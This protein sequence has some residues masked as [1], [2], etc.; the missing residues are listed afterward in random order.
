M[1]T[2]KKFEHSVGLKLEVQVR[3]TDVL[4]EGETWLSRT[5]GISGL[6]GSH[7][8]HIGPTVTEEKIEP[9]KLH[10]LHHSHTCIYTALALFTTE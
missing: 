10:Y 3:V 1:S 6:S 2:Q 4:I 9:N 8:V 7:I 5:G